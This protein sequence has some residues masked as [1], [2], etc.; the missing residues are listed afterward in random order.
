MK[1]AI[2]SVKE[3]FESDNIIITKISQGNRANVRIDAK[4]RFYKADHDNFFSKWVSL[5]YPNKLSVERYG[6]K[7]SELNS[8]RY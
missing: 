4:T 7:V 3:V 5:D 2:N 8:F 6:K 1:K